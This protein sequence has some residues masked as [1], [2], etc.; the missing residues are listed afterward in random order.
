MEQN[1]LIA[2]AHDIVTLEAK[3]KAEIPFSINAI[4]S[5]ARGR[6]KETAHSRVL[7]DI[8]KFPVFQKSFLLTF[9]N[10]EVAGLMKVKIEQP[11]ENK[12]VSNALGRDGSKW[13]ID[14]LLSDESHYII[15]ENKVNDASETEHQIYKY[16]Y[17]DDRI[18]HQYGM[19]QVYVVYLNS[20][21]REDPSDQSVCFN[22][23]NVKK[24]LG[25]RFHALSF[26]EDIYEWIK[27][28]SKEVNIEEHPHLHS[29]LD[30]YIDYLETQ[31]QLSKKYDKMNE[32]M[33]QTLF[34][35]LHLE[36][37]S[38]E[39]KIK[40]LEGTKKEVEELKK[41]IDNVTDA[42]YEEISNKKMLQ[43]K[44]HFKNNYPDLSIHSDEHSFGFQLNFDDIKVWCG[45]WDSHYKRDAKDQPIW[46]FQHDR[47]DK[48]ITAKVEE[49]LKEAQMDDIAHIAHHDTHGFMAWCTTKHGVERLSAL[50]E[51][52]KKLGYIL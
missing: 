16:V 26:R 44:E 48:K 9:L 15:M 38:N 45:I 36:N 12:E 17:G 31:F 23:V 37:V 42:L 32:D 52:S 8:L 5:A 13:K 1:E 27:K 10:I 33:K 25:E 50:Y 3:D 29:A 28:I 11:T 41:Q 21:N 40:K 34:A 7:A 47:T 19:S 20:W 46:A 22:G 24:E 35:A 18:K 30:Q 2:L 51:A 39:Q 43:W 4:A 14:I 49:I 6:L